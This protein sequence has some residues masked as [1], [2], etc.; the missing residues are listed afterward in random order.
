MHYLMFLTIKNCYCFF[1][2]DRGENAIV[3]LGILAHPTVA[4]VDVGC[5]DIGI[6]HIR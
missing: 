3:V 1:Y 5:V 2:L 4:V 6:R